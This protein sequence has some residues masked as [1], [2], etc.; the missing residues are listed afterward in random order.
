[1]LHGDLEGPII[2]RSTPH[3]LY[4]LVIQRKSPASPASVFL[5]MSA[6]HPTAQRLDCPPWHDMRPWYLVHTQVDHD[7][8]IG[9][10]GQ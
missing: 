7:L 1:M 8:K 2:T 3:Y 5:W 4:P 9:F 6:M 10:S